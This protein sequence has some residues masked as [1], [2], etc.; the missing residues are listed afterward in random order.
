MSHQASTLEMSK[1]LAPILTLAL[2]A[3]ITLTSFNTYAA[4]AV[5]TVNGK[6]ISQKTFDAYI[7]HKQKQDPKFDAKKG[8]NI[9]IQELVNRELMYQDALKKKL[10]K[11]KEV[12]FQLKQ[13]RID[14]L[15]KHA[16]RKT[17]LA[18]PITDTELKLEYDRRV[19]SANVKEFKARHIL[20][21]TKDKALSVIKELD[22][23]KNFIKLAK[24]YS[25]GPTG[26]NGGDLGWFNSR[27]MV[28]EFSKAVVNMEKGKYTKTP[29]QTKFGWH[30]IKLEDI[31]QMDPPKFSEIKNQVRIIMQNKKLQEYMAKL[32][33]KSKIKIN[34]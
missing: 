29:V 16:I 30:V 22:N 31:R 28:P 18:T 7:E 27:Q 6:A 25:T 23:G 24:A 5:A 17:M 33:K 12:V 19:K 14:L 8:R 10:D 3:S 1:F 13:Q 15:I 32:R 21:K 34:K 2:S 26:K 4:K 9:L 11:D 20:V